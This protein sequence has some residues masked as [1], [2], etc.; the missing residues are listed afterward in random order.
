MR[1]IWAVCKRE[2]ASYFT[3]PVGYVVVGVFSLISGLGFATSFI[4][5]ARITAAPSAYDYPGVPD[6][7]ERLLSPY[8]V[9][10]GIL[11]MFIGPFITMRLMAEEKHRGTMEL[12][13]THPLRNRDIIFGKYFAALG[14]LLVMMGII[15]VQLGVM[16]HYVEHVEMAVLFFGLLTVFL[17]SASFVSLGLFISAMARNQITAAAMTFGVLFVSYVLGSLGGDL[18]DTLAVGATWSAGL[19]RAVAFFYG[20]FRSLVSELALDAHAKNMAQGIVQPEDIAYYVLV[21]A[22]FLF[23]TFRVLDTRKWRA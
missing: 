23:L 1:N 10:C 4:F 5:Y 18:P 3:T 14:M 17:M 8:L 19:Q 9:F 12:L 21:A 6:F 20:L 11:I 2:F 15:G 22:V 13:L 7:E 16:A